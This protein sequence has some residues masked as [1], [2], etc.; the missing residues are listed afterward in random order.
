MNKLRNSLFRQMSLLAGIILL[1]LLN[2]YISMV[3]YVMDSNRNNVLNTN[4]QIVSQIQSE[5][6]LFCESVNHIASSLVYSPTVYEYFRMNP[7]EYA[8]HNDVLETVYSNTL[9]LEEDIIGVSLYDADMNRI[10][11]MGKD[12]GE[13][14]EKQFT[15]L[16]Q[17]GMKFSNI[18]IYQYNQ[19]EYYMISFPVFDLYSKEYGKQIG[20]S[21]LVMRTDS[22]K[23]ILKEKAI[24]EKTEVYLLDPAGWVV[25]SAGAEIPG[26]LEKSRLESDSDRYVLQEEAGIEGWKIVDRIPGNEMTEESNGW[27]YSIMVIFAV[28]ALLIVILL[29]FCYKRMIIPISR[30]DSFVTRII[31]HPEARMSTNRKDEIGTVVQ[32]L[33]HMLDEKAAL[34]RKVKDSLKKTYETELA[35]NQLEVLAYRNQ[36]NPHFLYNTFECIRSMALYHDADDIAGMTM[37]L[38]HMFRYAAKSENIVT[39]EQEVAYIKEYAEIIEYRFMGKMNVRIQME[40]EVAKTPVIKLILQPLV[41]NAVFH[42]LERKL[43]EGEVSVIV[44]KMN[45]TYMRFVVEDNGCGMD[46]E[47]LK[48]V[49]D[50]LKSKESTKGIG[51]ANIYQR[52]RLFYDDKMTFDIESIP[53]KGTK[54]TIVLPDTVKNGERKNV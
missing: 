1:V 4:K 46:A 32:S 39:V 33:N 37:A 47:T 22:L 14:E 3:N 27:Y 49:L 24:T 13:I 44:E 10:A 50:T 11:S 52:L 48:Q 35:K 41:E 54:V 43:D 40:D 31:L 29:Y 7:S 9:L 26:E 12:V 17:D 38:S 19:L 30:I 42:G 20:L 5:V 45:D 18:Y 28:A 36:M 21:V 53:Q 8:I 23:D 15:G 16:W 34:D 51:I 2:A 25:A 6:E